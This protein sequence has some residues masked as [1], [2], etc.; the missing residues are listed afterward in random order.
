MGTF[1]SESREVWPAR[2][3][4]TSSRPTNWRQNGQDN[5]AAGE[6]RLQPG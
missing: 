3:R 2:N 1:N 6:S 4:F 5:H